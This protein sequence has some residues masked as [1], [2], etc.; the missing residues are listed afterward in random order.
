M[1]VVAIE[2]GQFFGLQHLDVDQTPVDRRE[3]QRFEPEHLLLGALN[4]AFDDEHEV[5]DPDAVLASLII[6][7]LVRKDHARLQGLIAAALRAADGRDALRPFVDRQ[8]AADAV[9]GAMRIIEAGFPQRPAREA[10]EL[11]AARTLGEYSRG[12]R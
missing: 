11:A 2:P 3:S 5:F 4:L 10:V 7:G 1:R 6:A 12:N 9:A 8:E